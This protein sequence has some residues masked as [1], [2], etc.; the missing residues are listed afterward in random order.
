L[1]ALALLFLHDQINRYSASRERATGSTSNRRWPLAHREEVVGGATAG[2]AASAAGGELFR[3]LGLIALGTLVLTPLI[4]FTVPRMGT[5]QWREPIASARHL[6][7]FSDKVTLGDLGQIIE[8]PEEVM[9]VRLTHAESGELYPFHGELYLR[10]A[11][12]TQYND[13]QWASSNVAAA[14]PPHAAPVDDPGSDLR[15]DRVTQR[16][17]VEPLDRDELFC[18]WPPVDIRSNEMVRIEGGRLLRQAWLRGRR[19]AL[20]LGTTAFFEGRQRSLLSC[21]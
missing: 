20:S 1:S 2:G 6:V 8:S 13:Q 17:T 3:R 10:G 9:R 12:L 14:T 18:V 19:M 7:G 15:H 5:A 11:V 16:L 4:F 21:E